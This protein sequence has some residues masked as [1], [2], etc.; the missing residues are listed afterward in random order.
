MTSNVSA[1]RIE[2]VR[3][4]SAH[5]EMLQGLV[6]AP[7][8]LVIALLMFAATPS[9]AVLEGAGWRFG[10][11]ALGVLATALATLAAR[12]YRE[13]YGSVRPH[14]GV[15]SRY[16]LVSFVALAGV[17]VVHLLDL[18]TDASPEGL[19][20]SAVVVVA[21]LRAGPLA[22][23]LITAGVVG[24]VASALPLGRWAGTDVHPLSQMAV[25]LTAVALA[26]VVIAV[27]C[28]L[29]LRRVL[30]AHPAAGA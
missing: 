9:G 16:A 30:G 3:F 5:Y 24:A 8:M 2:D 12:R 17:L 27:W 13:R 28:H 23:P 15:G 11:V 22:P 7:G 18:R 6:V 26:Q 4:V 20:V 14:A 29:V 10:V 19:V 21:G 1:E 25:L